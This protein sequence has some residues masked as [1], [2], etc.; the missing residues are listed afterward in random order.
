[1]SIEINIWAILVATVMS[2]VIGYIWYGSQTFGFGKTWARLASIDLKKPSSPLAMLS[3]AV[4]AL[5]M[6]TALSV[7]AYVTHQY[8]GGGYFTAS[9]ASG[10]FVWIGFQGLRMFQRA[11]FNQDQHAETAIHI[12]NELATTM[13]MALVIGLF[14]V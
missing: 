9:V 5:V 7:V 14:G 10:L 6:A 8:L 4:S 12:G 2:M 3:A 11:Q 13:A 1:M